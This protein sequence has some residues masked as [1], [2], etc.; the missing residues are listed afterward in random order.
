[1]DRQVSKQTL[2]KERNLKIGKVAAAVAILGM[3]VLGIGLLVEPAVEGAAILLRKAERGD[4]ELSVSA[5]GKVIPAFEEIIS[6]PI[7]SRVVEVYKK[8]GDSLQ[9]G[10]PILK[11]DLLGAESNYK[12]MLDQEQ[13][14]EL[15]L[16]KLQLTN[17]GRISQME[18]NLK[19]QRME[20][21]RKAVNLKN[22]RYL[23]SLGSGTADRVREAELGY[24]VATLQLSEDEQKLLNERQLAAAD[25]KVKELE[26]SIFR[27]ELMQ[28]RKTY[29]DARILSPRKGV[30]T[31]VVNEIGAQVGRGAKV[32]IVSDLSHFKVEGEIADSYAG[33]IGVGYKAV[34]KVGRE[35]FTAMVSNLT[36]LSRNGMLS[37]NLQLDIDNAPLLRSGLNGEVYI[38]HSLKEEVVRIANGEYYNGPGDYQ[39]YVKEGGMLYRRDVRLGEC[40]FEY[41]EV[42]SGIQ[43]GEEVVTGGKIPQGKKKVKIKKASSK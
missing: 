9:A 19:V 24:N 16:N 31:F 13:M 2:K 28:V 1:M 33:K 3:V 29:E 4:I 21:N 20:L 5:S 36:P 12:N 38:L 39:L 22:E 6:S 41:V 15:E 25:E 11:L 10:T 23:D 18:M 30:L 17:R 32:A 14:K 26:L 37:F 7:D 42:L 34:L 35:R 43:E 27:K 8:G 40:N